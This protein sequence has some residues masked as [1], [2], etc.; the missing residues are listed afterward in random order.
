MGGM[1]IFILQHN[2]FYIEVR[3]EILMRNF[4]KA[5]VVGLCS[6]AFLGCNPRNI[7]ELSFNQTPKVFQTKR[8]S[9]RLEELCDTEIY[10]KNIT[11]KVYIQPSEILWD[12]HKYKEE[13]F[14]YVKE[15]FKEQQINC[16]VVYSNKQFNRFKKSDEFG[17]E[18]LE[19][20]EDVEKR[21]WKLLFG[22]D[23]KTPKILL[24][25][26][27]HAITRAQISLIK[28]RH[29]SKSGSDD[30]IKE[31]LLEIYE[32]EF[33]K[34]YFLKSLAAHFCHEVGHCMMLFHPDTLNP[35]P[36]SKIDMPN[37]MYQYN[38]RFP[39]IQENC[40]LGYGLTSL[41]QKIMHSFIAGNNT[42]RA[43][44]DSERD[45]RLFLNNL[46][47]ANNLKLMDY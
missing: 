32:D 15:F 1:S 31:A 39:K 42:Y 40:T 2:N 4:R 33:S 8:V 11:L 35:S 41:Q 3:F 38:D 30:S 13:L 43:F 25:D 7:R 47:E 19:S 28:G 17:I 36:I 46:A 21:Y 22:D 12:Y 20:K 24:Y 26:R 27:S 29:I 9:Y 45:L 14:G 16:N 44:L 10:E 37:I 6:L 5:L 34:E 18:V 23:D